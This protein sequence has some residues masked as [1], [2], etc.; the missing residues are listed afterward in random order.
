[1]RKLA[2][3][4]WPAQPRAR[5]GLRRHYRAEPWADLVEVYWS[6]DAEAYVTPV[7]ADQVGVVILTVGRAPFEEQ[8]AKFPLLRQRLHGSDGSK[9]L[10]AGPLWQRSRARVAGRV[11]LAGDAAGYVD[12][13]T[14]EGIAVGVAAAEVLIDCLA[15]DR[16]QDYERLWLR[17]TRRYRTLTGALLWT[18][19]RPV[20]RRGLVPT[21]AK[22]PAVFGLVVSQLAA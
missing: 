6:S 4:D 7:A 10:G 16:P 2:D 17:A 8:L 1:V 9:V 15:A 21:A 20:L 13:L 18:A 19:G 12:A 5:W 11:L 22:L 14:G 3:L